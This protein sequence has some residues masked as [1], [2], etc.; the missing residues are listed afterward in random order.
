MVCDSFQP[1]APRRQRRRSPRARQEARQVGPCA[2]YA[3]SAAQFHDQEDL[4]HPCYRARVRFCASQPPMCLNANP[5]VHELPGSGWQ[6]AEQ[7]K[8][9]AVP[10]PT[11]HSHQQPAMLILT[12]DIRRQ[13]VFGARAR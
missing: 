12:S 1:K 7:E 3:L 8:T 4:G 2:C 10:A 9:T 13:F 6:A 5:Y 11:H